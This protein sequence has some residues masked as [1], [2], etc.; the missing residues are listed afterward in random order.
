MAPSKPLLTLPN[1]KQAEQAVLGAII[2]NNL[3]MEDISD[4]LGFADFY[5]PAHQKIYQNMLELYEQNSPIDEVTLG[6][7]L[8]AK[9]LSEKTGGVDYLIELVQV[10]PVVENA[11]YYVKILQEMRQRREILVATQEIVRSTT[12]GAENVGV[13][14]D[15]ATEIF[16]ALE[17]ESD[18]GPAKLGDVLLEN[19]KKLEELSHMTNPITGV[20]TGFEELDELTRGFQAGDLLILAGRPSMGKTALAM[21]IAQYASVHAENQVSVF[22]LEMPKEQIAMRLL[23]GEAKVEM[24]K[25]WT[26]N[27]DN[28]DWDQL[29]VAAARMMDV[30]VWIDD[31]PTITPGHIRR[32][33][34]QIQKRHELGLIIVDYLQLMKSTER[35]LHREQEISEIS[36]TLKAIAKE[37]KVPVL[38]LSQLNRDLER[39]PDKRPKMA[40]L[41]ESGAIEQDADM[42]MFIYR[43]EVYNEESEDKGLAELI[44][45]KNRN[46][47]TKTIKLAFLKQY[48]KFV[49]LSLREPM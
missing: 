7:L 10:T 8:E 48:T 21:N 31:T 27:L 3:L 11:D 35:I 41:R 9:H 37:F 16:R 28:Q 18:L 43:D 45:A 14:V 6:N 42:I 23:G 29:A 47:A 25:L 26:G 39:R 44:V 12:E 13:V 30:K 24:S 15:R 33:I 2:L 34:R 19:F 17:N 36:R 1:D 46:G 40:D 38:A 20:P 5:S 49:N 32:T 22:S 4:T